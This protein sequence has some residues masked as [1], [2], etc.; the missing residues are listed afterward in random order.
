MKRPWL[1]GP[2]AQQQRTLGGSLPQDCF[3]VCGGGEI[4]LVLCPL[5]A[6]VILP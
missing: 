4:A 2:L 6:L 5:C 1:S 3:V